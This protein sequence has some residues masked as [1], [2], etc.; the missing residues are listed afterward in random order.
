MTHNKHESSAYAG[1]FV[2]SC[3]DATLQPYM[4]VLHN[5]P[6]K[7]YV[8]HKL[9][10]KQLTIHKTIFFHHIDENMCARACVCVCVCVSRQHIRNRSV[11]THATGH[12]R[13]ITIDTMV[14]SLPHTGRVGKPCSFVKR[15]QTKAHIRRI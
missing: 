13:P 11:L 1:Q 7:V 4:L 12:F 2:L 15:L 5:G 9:P 8:R 14:I 3:D 6:E 10:G